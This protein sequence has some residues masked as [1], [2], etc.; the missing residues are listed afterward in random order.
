MKDRTL[1]P[2][3]RQDAGHT[4]SHAGEAGVTD[5]V[6]LEV[7][8]DGALAAQPRDRA[9]GLR[10]Q[11]DGGERI[12]VR[13]VE[14]G[15]RSGLSRGRCGGVG[16]DGDADAVGTGADPDVE[17]AGGHQLGLVS[18][19]AAETFQQGDEMV[20]GQVIGLAGEQPRDM[21]A[22]QARRAH[23]IGL[24]E[25]LKPGQPVEGGGEVAHSASGSWFVVSGSWL[26]LFICIAF[27]K[28]REFSRV[29]KM[30]NQV[31]KALVSRWLRRDAKTHA[32]VRPAIY[33]EFFLREKD[34][35]LRG[36][37]RRCVRC[38][39]AGTAGRTHFQTDSLQQWCA[40]EGDFA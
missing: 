24:A 38:S 17:T 27:P 25:A 22:R 28:L 10:G 32:V 16:I 9:L 1:K 18:R 3:D 29:C 2:D 5:E 21:A 4:L 33:S 26:L 23:E 40:P 34:A 39:P 8:I 14:C 20:V 11:R 36:V 12:R 15:M 7:G 13:I 37:S 19:V 35:S 30:G 6:L 31:C